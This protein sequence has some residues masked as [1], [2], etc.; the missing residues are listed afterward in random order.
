MKKFTAMLIALIMVMTAFSCFAGDDP[1]QNTAADAYALEQVVILSRHNLHAPLS[2]N[3]PVPDELTPHSWIRWSAASS[4]LTLKGEIEETGM[5]H[6]SEN[7]W[8]RKA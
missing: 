7:G 5:G 4:E 3:G 1:G 6:T 8:I 2:S